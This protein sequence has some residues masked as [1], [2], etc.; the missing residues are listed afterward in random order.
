MLN[1]KQ[2][3]LVTLCQKHPSKAL[4]ILMIQDLWNKKQLMT[5]AALWANSGLPA[6]VLEI[7]K[8]ET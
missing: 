7:I 4:E 1:S 8:S 2:S 5:M 3:K 6:S